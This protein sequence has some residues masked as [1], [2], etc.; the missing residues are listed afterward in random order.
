LILN[1]NYI[2]KFFARIFILIFVFIFSPGSLGSAF[3]EKPIQS[4]QHDLS[5]AVFPGWVM[6]K[7]SQDPKPVIVDIRSPEDY[8]KLRIPQSMNLPLYAVKTKSF[9]RDRLIVLVNEGYV[10]AELA[11]E[12]RKLKQ[13]GFSVAIL[14][15]GLNAWN[16]N[17]G[18]LVGD[19]LEISRMKAITP[20]M[21]YQEKESE[22]H[23]LLDL[24]IEDG[25]ET[26]NISK[27]RVRIPV[28]KLEKYLSGDLSMTGKVSLEN[29][30]EFMTVLIVNER[31]SDCEKIEKIVE[32]AKTQ[33][34]FFLQGGWL[35]YEQYLSD[36]QL[37]SAPKEDRM[38]TKS[39]CDSC[40]E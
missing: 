6:A 38:V 25:A 5:F 31:G 24:S 9:L 4:A 13:Q 14:F 7:L 11:D 21:F 23:L 28:E 34:V 26:K 35:A 29:A 33:N 27:N 17:K 20:K 32:N 2:L 30:N 3:A 8:E 1:K 12:A 37:A 15:G 39:A 16:K 22:H 18:E 40:E 19:V 36:L 10:Y